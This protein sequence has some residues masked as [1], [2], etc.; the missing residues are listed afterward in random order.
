M[1]KKYVEAVGQRSLILKDLVD[2]PYVN[3]SIEVRKGEQLSGREC[4]FPKF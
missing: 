4:F 1:L 2:M 3:L